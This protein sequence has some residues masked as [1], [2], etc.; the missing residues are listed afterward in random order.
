MQLVKINLTPNYGTATASC[1]ID[2]GTP[3]RYHLTTVFCQW[4]LSGGQYEIESLSTCDDHHTVK[5]RSTG[6]KLAEC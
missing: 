6:R 1:K 2:A 3:T 4:L 5:W